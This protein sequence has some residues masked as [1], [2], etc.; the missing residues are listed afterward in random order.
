MNTS[1]IARLAYEVNEWFMWRVPRRPGECQLH[2]DGRF[3]DKL[4][5]FFNGFMAANVLS[6]LERI[7]SENI[8]LRERVRTLERDLEM[9]NSENERVSEELTRTTRLLD[10]AREDEQD[11]YEELVLLVQKFSHSDVV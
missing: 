11:I 3:K 10:R 6:E 2:Y 4:R 7:S 1:G 8:A 9:S 5:E